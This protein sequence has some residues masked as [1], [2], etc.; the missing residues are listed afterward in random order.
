MLTCAQ[1][2]DLL[3]DYELGD[4]SSE[5]AAAVD[6]HHAVCPTCVAFA[7]TYRAVPA[8]VHDALAVRVSDALQAEL[9]AT[10]LAALEQSA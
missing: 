9:D 4:L 7:R 6:A 1:I 2:T 3:L 8:M 5:E 10:V